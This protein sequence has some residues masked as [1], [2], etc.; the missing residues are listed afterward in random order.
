MYKEEPNMIREA[1]G[2]EAVTILDRILEKN[3]VMLPLSCR[4]S[5]SGGPNENISSRN[6][7]EGTKV[8]GAYLFQI[9]LLN[10]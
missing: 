5:N 6:Y 1:R 8:I 4:G 7:Y 3:I 10:D 9:A 2:N